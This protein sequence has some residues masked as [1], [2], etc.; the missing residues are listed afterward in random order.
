VVKGSDFVVGTSNVAL[1]YTL[2]EVALSGR[3]LVIEGDVDAGGITVTSITKEDAAEVAIQCGNGKSVFLKES[4]G[5][6]NLTTIDVPICPSTG[7]T[8]TV[9]GELI[10]TYM[11]GA[12]K[13]VT[14]TCSVAGASTE[15]CG[16]V[17][18]AGT[19]GCPA[20]TPT[21]QNSDRFMAELT[22]SL[23]ADV[24]TGD[25]YDD[26]KQCLPAGVSLDEDKD[27]S[28]VN[29]ALQNT[30]WCRGCIYPAPRGTFCFTVCGAGNLRRRLEEHTNLR[31]LQVQPIDLGTCEFFAAMAGTMATCTGSFD[32]DI[33]GGSLGIFPGTSVTGNFVGDIE[34]TTE[35]SAGCA[36]DGLAAWTAGRAMTGTTMLADMAGKTFTPGVYTQG[37][38]INISAGKVYLDAQGNSDAM[39]VFNVGTTLTTAASTEIVLLNGAKKDHVFWVL[40]TALTMG[41]DSIL[42][43]NVLA[44]TAITIGTN[45]IIMG[46]AIAQTFVTCASQ[47][48]I[49]S[50]NRYIADPVFNAGEGSAEYNAGVYTGTAGSTALG[51]AQDIIACLENT[52]ANYLCLGEIANMNL[53]VYA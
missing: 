18:P 44:G 36:V 9:D 14:I 25:E 38:S 30:Y 17:F 20:P 19:P 4:C 43:G 11:D 6:S 33:V 22:G 35:D 31:R 27:V 34:L 40:G 13:V 1:T 3:R 12:V 51:Y 47:C 53:V 39:F 32:C 5:D 23:T 8:E 46:R 15:T 42:V 7:T 50:N 16:V 10:Y 26:F 21:V 48:T 37:T 45:G 2:R 29:R 24:C 41:A 28:I 49:E 52:P